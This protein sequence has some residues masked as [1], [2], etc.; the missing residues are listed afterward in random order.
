MEFSSNHF[1]TV[2]VIEKVRLTYGKC[3]MESAAVQ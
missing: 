3:S 1:N 2:D